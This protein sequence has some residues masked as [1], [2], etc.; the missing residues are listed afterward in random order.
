MW[1]KKPTEIQE[2]KIQNE[3]KNKRKTEEVMD[4]NIETN[5]IYWYCWMCEVENE[6]RVKK[7]NR[8]WRMKDAGG[9]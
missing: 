8:K 5:I 3:D 1:Q 7:R 6:R 2:G 9:Q 4:K